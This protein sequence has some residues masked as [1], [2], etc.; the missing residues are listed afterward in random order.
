[1]ERFKKDL[2][3]ISIGEIVQKHITSGSCYVLEEGKY[4]DLKNQVATH[5]KIHPTEVIMV[6]S[7]KLGFSIVHEKRYRPFGDTSDLDLAIISPDLFDT[8]W[9]LVYEYRNQGG[10]WDGERVFKDYLFR[11]W[12]RPDKLPPSDLFEIGKNWWDFFRNLTKTN[13][14][15]PYK[16]SAGLYRSWYFLE[17]Y[18]SI[19]TNGCL[20]NLE[21]T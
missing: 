17:S 11:G 3:R 14:F 21:V 19:C 5:F 20:S 2:G 16:I 18:Q 1:M 4:F 12:I 15:G 7:G 13:A 6:G 8:I 9:R 10:Y